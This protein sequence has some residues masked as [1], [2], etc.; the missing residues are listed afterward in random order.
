MYVKFL[1]NR[2]K[3]YVKC[4]IKIYFRNIICSTIYSCVNE[5][6]FMYMYIVDKEEIEEVWRQS[7][8]TLEMTLKILPN[9]GGPGLNLKD[10]NILY[11]YIY[12][13]LILQYTLYNYN[14]T[15][16]KIIKDHLKERQFMA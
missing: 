9:S 12:N 7:W 11:Q 5:D 14:Q 10:V 6:L 13:V 3:Q 16:K 15:C 4:K 2:K 1:L 8:I